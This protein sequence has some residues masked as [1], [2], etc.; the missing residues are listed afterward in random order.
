M[1]EWAPLATAIGTLVMATVLV[2]INLDK[3]RHFWSKTRDTR[4]KYT[5]VFIVAVVVLAP[6]V[7]ILITARAFSRTHEGFLATDRA[8]LRNQQALQSSLQEFSE[9]YTELHRVTTVTLD[10]QRERIEELE[11]QV[12]DSRVSFGE[13]ARREIGTAYEAETDGFVSVYSGGNSPATDFVVEVTDGSSTVFARSRGSRYGGTVVP[14]S[15]GNQ[16]AVSSFEEEGSITV[17]W[18]P[19]DGS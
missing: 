5:A 2:I 3:L 14:V 6:W 19:V 1:G 18:L 8:S 17:Y 4:E 9:Q 11:N 7:G 12:A 10:L 13:W 15:K 16:W